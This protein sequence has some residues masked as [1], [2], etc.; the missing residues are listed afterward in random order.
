MEPE[1]LQNIY[2]SAFAGVSQVREAFTPKLVPREV[3]TITSVATGIAKVSGL[4]GVG[5]DELVKFPGDVLGIAFNVDT[6][7]IGVVLLGE[8]WH[9]HAGDEVQRTG[10][11]MDVAV[12]DGLMGR[13]IDP[14]GRPLDGNGPLVSSKR[15]PVE[16]TAAPIMD[17]AP[18]KVPLQT[19]IKVIDALIPV[20]RGQRELILGDRQTGKTTI[21]IDTILNQR[22]KD[23]LCVYCA[24]GQRASAVAKAV[25]T[26]REKGAMNYTVIVVTEGN[27]PP[28]L[29]YI[30]P[31]AAT[32]IAEFFMEA[33]RDVLIVYDDLTNHARAYRELSLLLRRPPGREAFPGDIFYI[34][35]RLLE[36]ATHLREELGDGSLTA[37]PIIETEAQNI[38]AYIPTNLISITDGQ[39]YLSPSLFQLGVLPAVDVGKSVSRVGGK[40]QRAAYRAVAGDLKL[41][42]AQFEELETFSR[43]GARLDEDTRKIIEHGRR[44]RACLKQPEFA[45]VSMPAQ[46]VVLLALTTGLIEGVPIDQM[47]DAEYALREAAAGIPEQLRERL[48]TAEKLSN[49][50]RETIIQI[51]RKSL[52]RFQSKPE[53]EE[54]S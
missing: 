31:Y 6:D 33:G 10:R 52:A 38:S 16:R 20:G 44:I 51:A 36:R 7:E 30:A 19:G 24:I 1:N 43:F 25:A 48:D 45:P 39:I 54:K 23:V 2:D 18:V 49:E 12:G 50:D 3:G 11:V 42:Y 26:L 4:P 8:Y 14:L 22:G 17:R 46:I 47:T 5:S 15:L 9:L 29:T 35:S 28:G 40:A 21:A 41:A 32:S 13:V 34:H 37:L 27:D 53:S